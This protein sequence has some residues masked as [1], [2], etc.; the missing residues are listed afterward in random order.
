MKLFYS[1]KLQE[2]LGCSYEKA[3]VP[4]DPLDGWFAEQVTLYGK[5]TVV[6]VLPQH[7]FCA[8]LYDVPPDGWSH[9]N[10]LLVQAI[11]TSLYYPFYGLPKALIN[12]YLPEDT[13]LEPCSS[14]D[15][16]SL[17]ALAYV[18]GKVVD[19]ERAYHMGY[20]DTKGFEDPEAIQ[21][22]INKREFVPK[23]QADPVEVW[24]QTI[25]LL[26]RRYGT[27]A[28]AMELEISLRLVGSQSAGRTLIIAADN[29]FLYLFRYMQASFFWK[30][31]SRHQFT[32][33]TSRGDISIADE[34]RL[35]DRLWEGDHLL[36][37][38][39]PDGVEVPWEIDISVNRYIPATEDRLPICTDCIGTA[40][41][42]MVGGPAEYVRFL[43]DVQGNSKTAFRDWGDKVA[44]NWAKEDNLERISKELLFSRAKFFLT[45]YPIGY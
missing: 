15:Q 4:K 38:Y 22:A 34:E 27:S 2:R 17:D 41:P 6:A 40:P 26:L 3:P 13:V 5:D 10:Q 30:N 35:T 33:Q 24:Q 31:G 12:W 42:E 16:Y 36:C 11:R 21:A 9:L 39:Y 14:D 43:Q 29:S 18:A 28:P 19:A 32:R 20:A 1:K 25:P 37:V 7:H 8:I 45:N 44:E 23:W